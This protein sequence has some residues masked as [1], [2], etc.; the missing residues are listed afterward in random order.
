[1]KIDISSI[2]DDDYYFKSMHLMDKIDFHNYEKYNH[3]I[4]PMSVYNILSGHPSWEGEFYNID[5]NTACIYVGKIFEYECY[6]DILMPH[7]IILLKYNKKIERDNKLE[8]I[9]NGTDLKLKKTIKIKH[10]NI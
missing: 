6:L 9:L 7:D 8:S 4:M 2:D 1:M 3:I 10:G 5:I